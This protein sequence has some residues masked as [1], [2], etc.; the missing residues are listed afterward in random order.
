M[1]RKYLFLLY[2]CFFI[3]CSSKIQQ[4]NTI[5]V[6]IEPQR[7]FAERLAKP[8]FKITTLVPPGTSPENYDPTP[9]QMALLGKSKA[10]F[11]VGHIGFENAWLEKLKQNNPQVR[12]FD[13]SQGISYI[14]SD[15]HRH[16]FSHPSEK[17][18]DPHA[19][20]SPKKTEIIVRNMYEAMAEIDPGNRSVYQ[21]NLAKLL[22]EINEIDRQIESYLKTSSQKSFI[23]YH[24]SLTYFAQDYGL[25]QHSIEKNGKEP[26]SELL[27]QL[28]NTAQKENIKTIFIQQEFD[29]K[30]GEIIA[31]ETGCRLIEINPLS[32]KWNEE[33]IQIAK[34]LSD[35]E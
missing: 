11:C 29:R 31:K 3:S 5:T 25:I 13:N 35:N 4:E 22:E 7:Y 28:I 16:D 34:A 18:I 2:I 15:D 23:I 10:Y 32:Y 17:G 8:F 20:I 24:P 6:T 14:I 30:N 1:R 12:F 21:S 26:S 33:V 19:W 9:Q 27:K